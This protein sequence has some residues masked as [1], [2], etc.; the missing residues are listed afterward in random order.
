MQIIMSYVIIITSPILSSTSVIVVICV[1]YNTL[2]N[3]SYQDLAV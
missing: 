2:L 3:S 1:T